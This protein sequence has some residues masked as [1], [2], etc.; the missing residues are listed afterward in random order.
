MPYTKVS[1][2]IPQELL[3]QA[4]GRSRDGGLS[5][6]LATA[7]ATQV[8]LD[9]AAEAI[10]DFEREHGEITEEEIAAA[11]QHFGV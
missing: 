7:L 10:A 2:T 1:V 6:Y 8:K 11:R 9:E 4:R 3:E 5:A